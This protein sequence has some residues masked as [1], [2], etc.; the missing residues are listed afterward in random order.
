MAKRSNDK[1]VQVL[2]TSQTSNH[3]EVANSKAFWTVI[4]HKAVLKNMRTKENEE[5]SYLLSLRS[6]R[7]GR[8]LIKI[9]LS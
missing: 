1:Y 2:I 9:M 8:D 3:T 7:N 4:S 6:G 5:V